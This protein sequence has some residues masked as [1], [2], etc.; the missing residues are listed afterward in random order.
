M[1]APKNRS[2]ATHLVRR[3]VVVYRKGD[4]MAKRKKV[5]CC[6]CKHY[7]RGA[8]K[9]SCAVATVVREIGSANYLHPAQHRH[10]YCWE[11]NEKNNC[12]DHE[13]K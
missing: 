5:Y 8:M 4:A 2:Y 7:G 3:S 6:D 11:K 9:E 10:E 12:K 13:H 1:I